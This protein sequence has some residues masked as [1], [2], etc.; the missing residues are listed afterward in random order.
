MAIADRWHKSRP[1]PDEPKCKTH[2]LVPSAEHGMG[3]RWAVR[4]RDENGKQ[5]S[6][7]FRYKSGKDPEIHAEAFDAKVKTSANSSTVESEVASVSKKPLTV[8]EVGEDWLLAQTVDVSTLGTMT[9]KVRKHIFKDGFGTRS[10]WELYEDPNLIQLWIKSLLDSGL[11]QSTARIVAL[12]LSSILTYAK[13]KDVIPSNPMQQNPLVKIPSPSRRVAIPYT[14]EQLAGITSCLREKYLITLR[15]G[16]ELGLRIGEI[17][18]LSPDD[19]HN[20]EV[21]VKRQ[22]RTIK[23]ETGKEVVVFAL[24]KRGKTRIVP[25]PDSLS[26]FLDTLPTSLVTL[27]WKTADGNP[28]TVRTYLSLRGKA[29]SRRGLYA[30]WNDAMAAAGIVSVPYQDKFHRLR[31]TYASRLLRNGVDIRSLAQYLGHDDPGFTLRRY[32]HFMTGSGD[33]VRRIFDVPD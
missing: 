31:H 24:P 16:S 22:I 20:R 9:P 14:S 23:T 13:W 7:N 17:Y 2:D 4:Y 12:H 6:K 26:A 27:P 18:G 1:K 15:A 5:C 19:L 8:K 3:D 21:Q 32:C 33:D 28:V 25:I 29:L 10:V 11:E 30:A